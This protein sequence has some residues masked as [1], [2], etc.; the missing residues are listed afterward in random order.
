[1]YLVHISDLENDVIQNAH[2]QID[3]TS[4]GYGETNTALMVDKCTPDENWDTN[5]N[6]NRPNLDN[7]PRSQQN[8]FE[9]NKEED[10][11]IG[12]YNNAM[13]KRTDKQLFQKHHQQQTQSSK[14]APNSPNLNSQSQSI[15]IPII[16]I[17][18]NVKTYP[19]IANIDQEIP[20]NITDLYMPDDLDIYLFEK[21]EIHLQP[22]T[23]KQT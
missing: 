4:V 14:S 15:P 17:G 2:A 7:I 18:M 22:C 16:D 12:A 9:D 3:K 8:Q 10:I 11:I 6:P 20:N 19:S 1:M 23:K 5:M 13:N 21:L